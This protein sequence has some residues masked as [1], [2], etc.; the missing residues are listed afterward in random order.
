MF[1]RVSLFGHHLPSFFIITTACLHFPAFSDLLGGSSFLL[2]PV[3][4]CSWHLYRGSQPFTSGK[5]Q[6]LAA[7]PDHFCDI[8]ARRATVIFTFQL[9][10]GFDVPGGSSE[11][12]EEPDFRGH[13]QKATQLGVLD[14]IAAMASQ[15]GKLDVS[16][17][18]RYIYSQTLL[19]LVSA[20]ICAFGLTPSMLSA[21]DLFVLVNIISCL[22]QGRPPRLSLFTLDPSWMLVTH[23]SMFSACHVASF[24]GLLHHLLLV[25]VP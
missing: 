20:I 21:H 17:D 2:W 15:A 1:T 24:S 6:R 16:P 14:T 7:I 10:N 23:P 5:G 13:A 9:T 3:K 8:G 22:F 25:V 11:R 4:C 12:E 19:G 18:M